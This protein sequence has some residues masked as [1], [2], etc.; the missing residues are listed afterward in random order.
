MNLLQL[1]DGMFSR[2]LSKLRIVTMRAVLDIRRWN[3]LPP[4]VSRTLQ[5]VPSMRVTAPVFGHAGASLIHGLC[6]NLSPPSHIH[7]SAS[8][9]N[10]GS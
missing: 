4:E 6:E 10:H 5:A 1:H 7:S 8:K 9:H 3:R 2:A